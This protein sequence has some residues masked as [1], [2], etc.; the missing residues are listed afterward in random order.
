MHIMHAFERNGT[1]R[2][3]V[4]PSD[5]FSGFP[6]NLCLASSM[7]FPRLDAGPSPGPGAGEPKRHM[8]P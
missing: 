7:A 5:I 8:R 3:R 4:S 6:F 2:S 1:R